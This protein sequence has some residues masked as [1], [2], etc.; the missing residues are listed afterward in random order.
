MGDLGSKGLNYPWCRSGKHSILSLRCM[1]D[2]HR[3]H[4]AANVHVHV[5]PQCAMFQLL[6]STD[7]RPSFSDDLSKSLSEELPEHPH[8]EH[9]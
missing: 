7:G 1:R 2:V 3:R 4:L 6:S 5:S 8:P 9:I